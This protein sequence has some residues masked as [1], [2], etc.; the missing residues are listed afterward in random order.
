MKLRFYLTLWCS[1]IVIA[2]MKATGHAQDDRP[3]VLIYK[4]CPD[5]LD[6]VKKPKITVAVT[7]TNGKTS[8]SSMIADVL[9]V[10]GHTVTYNDW[11]ANLKAGHCMIMANSVNMFNRPK[12]DATVLE[13]DEKTAYEDMSRIQP[14][15]FIVSN[16]GRDS[17]RRNG[18][19]LYIRQCIQDTVDSL[20]ESVIILNADDPISGF[21]KTNTEPVYYAMA[22]EPD[23]EFQE[24]II[25]DFTV[26]PV[27]HK[28]PEYLHRHY[29]H[30]GEVRC[31]NCGMKSPEPDFNGVELDRENSVLKVREKGSD[32]IF[33]YNIAST[34][35][36][37]G[38]NFLSLIAY[39]RSRGIPYEE[40][41]SALSQVKLPESRE[42]TSTVKGIG[43]HS[44]MCKGQTGGS[45]SVVFEHLSKE[46][47][48][49][50]LILMMNEEYEGLDANETIT[51]FYDTD[52]EL[53]NKPNIKKILVG[54]PVYADYK[55][56]MKIAG[57]PDDRVVCIEDD[58]KIIDYVTF[59]DIDQIYILH[60]VNRV[61]EGRLL[62]EAI[63]EKLRRENNEN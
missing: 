35:I 46:K 42:L 8:V 27:C 4:L 2:L 54:G 9:R 18:H 3:G 34:S 40:L 16:I 22:G 38:F 63:E 57:I 33:E 53:L 43:I 62:K 52:Y 60:E 58:K 39:F 56:R 29:L 48:N 47:G 23:V 17:M 20:K 19:P 1:K 31:P 28:R 41:K 6:Y 24:P 44:S 51:W 12:V 14:D 11:G 49:L 13:V 55:L 15:Y 25:K 26:C 7:G 61:T 10:Q 30:I 32:E 59:E 21:L 45:A 5:F 50:E 37:N 36:F